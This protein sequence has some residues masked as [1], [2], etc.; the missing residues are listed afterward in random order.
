MADRPGAPVCRNCGLPIARS[1]D[2]LAVGVM[3]TAAANLGV[4]LAN[5][6][7]IFN[8]EIIVLG[9]GVSQSADI[10]FQ[11]VRE[12]VA[13]RIM[14]DYSVRIEPAALGGARRADTGVGA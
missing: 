12:V 4:G 2:P 8:P 5:F 3:H 9:G 10:L 13:E 1:G 6:V 14:P 11:H 7:H